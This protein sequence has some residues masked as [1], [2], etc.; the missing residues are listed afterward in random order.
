MGYATRYTLRVDFTVGGK[1]AAL[2]DSEPLD[3][4]LIALR[5]E[6]EDARH[7]LDDDGSTSESCKWYEHQAQMKEF[8]AKHPTVLF[9]LHGEGEE[10]EDIWNEYYLGGKLQVAKAQMQI[11]PFDPKKL[12]E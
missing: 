12:E 3:S 10:N 8:S 2:R 5:E 6:N 9:T 11:A 1:V 7:A 4:L